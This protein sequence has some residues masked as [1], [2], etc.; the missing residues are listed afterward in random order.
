MTGLDPLTWAVILLLL[1]CA[2]VVLEVFIP[3]GGILGLLSGFAVLASIVFAFRS[4]TTSG[5]LFILCALIAVPAMLGL[6]F[7]VWPY[8]PMGRAFLGELPSEEEVK[9]VDQ[10]KELVGRMG[11]A[12]SLMLPSGVVL[13][14]GKRLDAISQG[15]AIEAGESIVVAEVRGNRVV[16]RRADPDEASQVPQ[17]QRDVLSRSLDE[18]G[19]EEIDDPEH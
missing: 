19:L 10:R 6:A 13:V 8:T 5:L 4:D 1:G 3:S 11:I 16:V 9:P 2:L 17:D 7:K 15:D 18:F 12:K 14:D